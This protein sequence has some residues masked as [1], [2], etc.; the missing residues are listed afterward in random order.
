ME[1]L[2][3]YKDHTTAGYVFLIICAVLFII[4]II[5]IWLLYKVSDENKHKIIVPLAICS[6][7][8]FCA[9]FIGITCIVNGKQYIIRIDDKTTVKELVSTY[10]VVDYDST[11]DTWDVREKSE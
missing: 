3:E 9:F 6:V 8:G 1:V 2:T 4:A 11:H 7:L 5:L 10:Y